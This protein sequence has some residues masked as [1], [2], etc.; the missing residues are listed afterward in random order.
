MSDVSTNDPYLEFMLSI[1]LDVEPRDNLRPVYQ[2]F[3]Y[4]PIHTLSTYLTTKDIISIAQANQQL[5]QNWL[6]ESFTHC[7]IYNDW[8]DDPSLTTP[9]YCLAPTSRLNKRAVPLSAFLNPSGYSYFYPESV[10]QAEFGSSLILNPAFENVI[11]LDILQYYP[12]LNKFQFGGSPTWFIGRDKIFGLPIM[13]EKLEHA[14]AY[15]DHNQYSD[16]NGNTKNQSIKK[17]DTQSES[18][19]RLCENLVVDLEIVG[20]SQAKHLKDIFATDCLGKIKLRAVTDHNFI[21]KLLYSNFLKEIE[22]MQSSIQVTA[23]LQFLALS[24]S[25]PSLERMIC[26]YDMSGIASMPVSRLAPVAHSTILQVLSIPQRAVQTENIYKLEQ[27][28]FIFHYESA[29]YDFEGPNSKVF[30]EIV[31]PPSEELDIL[32]NQSFTNVTKY[33]SYVTD[34]RF[35]GP[36][37]FEF[38]VNDLEEIQSFSNLRA[39]TLNLVAFATSDQL[40][41]IVEKLDYLCLGICRLNVPGAYYALKT[42]RKFKYSNLKKLVL[43]TPVNDGHKSPYVELPPKRPSNFLNTNENSKRFESFES[44][45]R[46]YQSFLREY[47]TIFVKNNMAV[48]SARKRFTLFRSWILSSSKRA[49]LIYNLAKFTVQ[50]PYELASMTYLDAQNGL[51]EEAQNDLKVFKDTVI[52][53]GIGFVFS[54]LENPVNSYQSL[55]ELFK[56]CK[57]FSGGEYD[58]VREFMHHFV[59]EFMYQLATKKMRNLEYVKIEGCPWTS[60]LSYNFHTLASEGH[61][62]G[63]VERDDVEGSH[64]CD[65]TVDDSLGGCFYSHR[66]D[67]NS[68]DEKGLKLRQVKVELG[69]ELDW[70]LDESVEGPHADESCQKDTQNIYKDRSLKDQDWLTELILESRTKP[71]QLSSG[72]DTSTKANIKHLH[73]CLFKA[74]SREFPFWNNILDT[75]SIKF[76]AKK[77]DPSIAEFHEMLKKDK[78]KFDKDKIKFIN[79]TFLFDVEGLRNNYKG[80]NTRQVWTFETEDDSMTAKSWEQWMERE[81]VMI[82]NKFDGWL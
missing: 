8:H 16:Q 56:Y 63:C 60:F 10:C 75:S 65:Q 78:E 7:A 3:L 28:S 64:S 55:Y 24:G 25:F 45:N 34:I 12:N 77:E 21:S 62:C 13:N 54:L 58:S 2:S 69:L 74:F 15:T 11:S 47:L 4:I 66:Y 81:D 44:Y 79:S 68:Q 46:A 76:K 18:T 5:R 32:L 71:N 6:P 51:M 70:F 53:K 33:L 48:H 41:L 27:L 40:S 35:I 37:F 17:K 80:S 61:S 29:R 52:D 57:K 50:R 22:I 38:P 72:C 23:H 36:A 39:L 1:T 31:N 59:W 14:L 67:K 20:D 73:Q 26:H 9:S 30:Q 49:T 19:R 82:S 43:T 42:L